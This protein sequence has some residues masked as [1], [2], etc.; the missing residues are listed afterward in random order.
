[1]SQHFSELHHKD[2][3]FFW[4]NA[5]YID[6]FTIILQID[7]YQSQLKF[8]FQSLYSRNTDVTEFGGNTYAVALIQI[9]QHL[10]VLLFL[11]LLCLDCAF[12]PTQYTSALPLPSFC[13]YC[14]L[15]ITTVSLPLSLLILSITASS[16]CQN[17]PHCVLT[18]PF[19]HIIQLITLDGFELPQLLCWHSRISQFS[20]SL[21]KVVTILQFLVGCTPKQT[22]ALPSM[23]QRK[24]TEM[25]EYSQN[26]I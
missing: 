2:T 11:L 22:R 6:N 16:H 18:F 17:L 13:V 12:L 24:I 8:C 25:F 7:A 5:Q 20:R 10:L 9:P 1:M 4:K 21:D 19:T 3:L 15:P 26:I 14:W 23:L